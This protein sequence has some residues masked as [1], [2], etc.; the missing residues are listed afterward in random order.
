VGTVQLRN[1]AV[2]NIKVRPRSL[3]AKVFRRGTLLRGPRGLTGAR[4]AQGVPGLQGVQGVPGTP[5]PSA[6]YSGSKD[7]VSFTGIGSLGSLN[8]PAGKYLIVATT[9]AWN[10][11]T[12]GGVFIDCTLSAGTDTDEKRVELGKLD[13]PGDAQSIA[14]SLAHTFASAGTIG[15]SCN[16]FSRTVEFNNTRI[17]AIQAGTLTSG[18]LGA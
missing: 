9:W 14:F 4:G 16:V 13:D 6:A 17:S 11:N 5:G 10:I 18:A 1:G 12:T 15:I 7:L 3:T 2:T 8:V